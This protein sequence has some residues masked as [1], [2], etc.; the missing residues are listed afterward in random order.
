MF[1][2]IF[3]IPAIGEVT[4]SNVPSVITAATQSGILVP[5]A[6]ARGIAKGI[7][8]EAAPQ[9]VPIKKCYSSGNDKNRNSHS[10]CRQRT[11]KVMLDKNF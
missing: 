4:S 6:T 8:K 5:D 1:D 3:V 10:P 11:A 9:P 7:I 2:A